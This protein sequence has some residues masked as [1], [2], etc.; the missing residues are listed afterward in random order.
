MPDAPPDS[1]PP[2]LE[3]EPAARYLA[4]GDSYTIGEG[5]EAPG[6]WPVQLAEALRAEGLDVAA[7]QI[8][9]VTGWTVEEL[10]AGIDAAGPEGPFDL[11]TLL[12]G[13]NDQYR[14]HG[15]E[16]YRAA[17]RAL[18]AR[19]VAFAGGDPSRVVA[20]SFP[21]WGRTPFGGRDRRSR[22]EI[23]AGV[24]AFNA[25]AEA[26]ARA[27]GA[28]WVD[29]TAL[30]RSQGALVVVDE[31]HPNAAAYAAWVERILPAARAALAA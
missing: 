18:L 31:L 5:V 20:V 27:A 8:V 28:A 30:S 12:I 24:D 10:D 22:D 16:R 4:L 21:D 11:V 25:V 17:Y 19:A 2:G 1:A 23:A 26:E 29:V 9:A 14:G 6:R 13:V 3:A 15:L 7:P